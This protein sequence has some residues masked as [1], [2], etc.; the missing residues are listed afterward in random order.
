MISL[1][2]RLIREQN[3]L[4]TIALKLVSKWQKGT[5]VYLFHDILESKMEVKT[6]FALSQPSFELFLL[7]QVDNGKRALSFTELSDSILNNKKT[8]NCFYVSFDD[9]NASVYSKA[10][11]FLKTH[12]IPFVLFITKELIGKPNFLTAEQIVELAKEP[13]CTIGSHA[14]HHK[15]FRY[16][17]DTEA[18]NELAASRLYLQHLTGQSIDCF[19]FPYGRLVEVSCISIKLLSNSEYKFAFSAIAGNLNQQW[20]SGKYYLPR[21]NVSE[22]MVKRVIND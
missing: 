7:Q 8:S 16:M 20:F 4:Y 3:R 14:M 5:E 10:Y 15:M 2:L 11:P 18:T 13:L 6:Q 19:A 1:K 22:E 12:K 17:T 9:C 21:V